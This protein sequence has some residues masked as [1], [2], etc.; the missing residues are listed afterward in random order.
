MVTDEEKLQANMN[1]TTSSETGALVEVNNTALNQE[2]LDILNQLIAETDA[3]KTKDLTYLFNA[4]QNKKTMVR[5]DKLSSL[6]D[7]LVDQFSKRIH[8][9]P[10]EISNQDLMG[11]LKLTQDIIERGQKQ[12]VSNNETPLIQINHQ[13]NTLTVGDATQNLTKESRDRVKNTVMDIL[14]SLTQDAQPN[15]I[16]D[17]VSQETIAEKQTEEKETETEP[18]E[19]TNDN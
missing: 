5:M 6:Q 14:S 4:N 10:D 3:E 18:E 1:S 8:E 9:R 17:L 11:A 7:E 19:A 2:S 13:T 15:D 12:I 16:I